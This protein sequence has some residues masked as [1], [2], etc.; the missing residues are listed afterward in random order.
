LGAFLFDKGDYVGAEPLH[1]RALAIREKVLGPEHPDTATS[2]NNLAEVLLRKRDYD[3]AEPLFRR[4]LAI[5]EKVLGADRTETAVSM[6]DLGFLLANKHEAA[7]AETL[8]RRAL[9][10]QEKVLGP[11]NPMVAAVATNLALLLATKKDYAEAEVLYRRVLAI[12]EKVLGPEHPGTAVALTALGAFLF[13]KGDYV[14]AEPLHRRALAIREKA[15]GNEH[16]DTA[17]SRNN[18][19]E[20]L[21]RKRDYDAAESLFRDVLAIRER[22]LG[23]ENP[24]TAT[25]LSDLGVT[26]AEKKEN[27]EAEVLYRR[28]LAIREKVLGPEHFL[29]AVSLNIL[30]TSLTSKGDYVGAEML[31][32][33]ELAILEKISGPED[34]ATATALDNLAGVLSHKEDYAGAE[35]LYHRALAIREKTFGPDNPAT[36]ALMNNLANLLEEKGDPSAAEPLYRRALAIEEEVSGPEDPETALSLHN[37]AWHLASNGKYEEAE[38]LYRRALAI[39][40]KALGPNDPGTPNWLYNLAA[41]LWAEGRFT[42]ARAMG[43]RASRL[44]ASSFAHWSLPLSESEQQDVLRTMVPADGLI[45]FQFAR[46]QDKETKEIERLVLWALLQRKGRLQEMRA[47]QQRLARQQPELFQRWVAAQRVLGV[48][49]GTGPAPLSLPGSGLQAA[50]GRD[51]DL[52]ERLSSANEA[53]L[54]L[55]SSVPRE[56]QDLGVVE[57]PDLLGLLREGGWTLVEIARYRAY[58]PGR[59]TSET[60]GEYRYAAYALVADG[61]IESAD[62]G[63]AA[64]IDKTVARLRGLESD[65]SSNLAVVRRV[66]QELYGQTLGKLEGVL[67]HLTKLYLAADGDLGLI[68]FSSLVDRQGRW[69][70]E[71]HL[72]VNLTSGRDLVRLKR[73]ESFGKGT[74][75]DYLV[76]NPSFMFKN[77]RLSR[78][79]PRNSGSSPKAT[80]SAPSF[81]CG[82]AFGNNVSWPLVAITGN[83]VSG[84]RTAI[85]GLKVLERGQASE[86]AVKQ[87][88]RPRSLWFITHGFFCEDATGGAMV[89]SLQGGRVRS[90]VRTYDDPMARGALV[91]AGAQVGGTGDGEDGFLQGSEIV[92][93]DWEGTELVVLGACE[94]ALGVPKVGDGVYGI[95][96]ALALAGVRSQVMTLWRVSQTQTF[97]LLLTFANLLRQGKGKAEAL[98]DAQREMLR[99]APHP[100]YWAGFYFT[101]DPAPLRTP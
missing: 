68:D 32:R 79:T 62:L 50:C 96:R 63:D 83:Q 98:R 88:D 39:R 84:F 43:E 99:K 47:I 54:K 59:P 29:T 45:S 94:T 81:T 86:G 33:R 12:Q 58:H 17:T 90:S 65:S 5:R 24:D 34:P 31:F 82:A 72:V 25:T 80:L 78:A 49:A 3:A 95:R 15:L 36:A 66:A 11:E 7:E 20:V 10:I 48:C 60:W 70:I 52:P 75:G 14:G 2:L 56:E 46:P 26:L 19:G 22:V 1:R 92:E 93:R 6:N 8:Y 97:E 71:N 100:Y 37:L 38:P 41:L 40:D 4:A 61:R 67:E 53:L 16:P 13:D 30:A 77:D 51:L 76:A 73:A 64:E 101:G 23:P 57:L 74:H 44:E 91:L 42:E 28:A 35:P 55:Y 69:F 89:N 87:I 9:A 27:V 85:P 21:L 18:L